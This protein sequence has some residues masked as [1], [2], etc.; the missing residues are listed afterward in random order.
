M[1]SVKSSDTLFAT[2]IGKTTAPRAKGV[3]EACRLS[4]QAL[5]TFVR[6]LLKGYRNV[7]HKTAQ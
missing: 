7:P 1:K 2:L 6:L 3:P 4:S 5:I